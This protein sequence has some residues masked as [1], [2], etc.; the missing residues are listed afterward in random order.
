MLINL[1][2]KYLFYDSSEPSKI[3]DFHQP[4]LLCMGDRRMVRTGERI[5]KVSEE[6]QYKSWC[7]SGKKR[8]IFK[9]WLDHPASTPEV[10]Q[11]LF[12]EGLN[13]FEFDIKYVLRVLCDLAV[14]KDLWIYDTKGHTKTLK[15][16]VYDI[17]KFSEIISIIGY[18]QFEVKIKSHKN[19]KNEEFSFEIEEIPDANKLL[20]RYNK[21]L[22]RINQLVAKSKTEEVINLHKFIKLVMGSHIISGHNIYEYDNPEV[23]DR[24]KYYVEHK[25]L[26]PNG[27]IYDDFEEFL[28]KYTYDHRQFNQQFAKEERAVFFY[29]TCFDTYPASQKFLRYLDTPNFTLKKLAPVLGFKI[30]GRIYLRSNELRMDNKTLKY[31][32]DDVMEQICLSIIMLQQG[33]PMAFVSNY[34]F[35]YLT[36]SGNI[37]LWD[38]MTMIRAYQERVIFQPSV[39]PLHTAQELIRLFPDKVQLTKEE[40]EKVC[41][42]SEIKGDLKKVVRYGVEMPNWVT[43]PR[44]VVN[45]LT[46]GGLPIKPQELGSQFV[47]WYGVVEA[48]VA[49]MYP[50][51]LISSNACSDKVRFARVDEKPDDWIML[52]EMDKSSMEYVKVKKVKT[53]LGKEG[54]RV[55]IKID[56]ERGLIARP[57]GGLLRM[58]GEVRKRRKESEVMQHMYDSLKALRNAGTHGIVLANK[59]ACRQFNIA[60]G[61]LITTK[62]QDILSDIYKMYQKN[63]IRTIY[64]D[65]DGIYAACYKSAYKVKGLVESLS[66]GLDKL[67]DA[68]PKKGFVITPQKKVLKVIEEC[69]RRWRKKLNYKD[70]SFEVDIT[71]AMIIS[72]HKNYI[73]IK[74]DRKTG[75]AKVELKGANFT[76]KDKPNIAEDT[77]KKIILETVKENLQWEDEGTSAMKVTSAIHRLLSRAIPKVHSDEV[78]IKDLVLIQT[79]GSPESYKDTSGIYYKRAVALEELIGKIKGSVRLDFVVTKKPLPGMDISKKVYKPTVKPIAFM[80]PIDWIKDK[81]EIDYEWYSSMIMDY[82]SSCFKFDKKRIRTL[83]GDGKTA[84]MD[85]ASFL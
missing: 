81:S 71:P 28:E 54:F 85:L 43:L 60:S 76:A 82:V 83:I 72:M 12:E 15:V 48:D 50:N 7:D 24:V 19:L 36:T 20:S 66:D 70:F 75:K 52:W 9:V 49:G 39:S 14:D 34:P 17:E 77:L 80:T 62:G 79:V 45:H 30:K 55:G 2:N 16:L 31:N 37:Q 41:R 47:L 32:R 65:T 38:Y 33:L 21:G 63:R 84:Q 3:S 27:E 57:M 61:S 25:A 44:L 5:K 40:I 69:N 11:K 74:I 68:G 78:D 73:K 10:A 18:Y 56:K 59:W 1:S 26:V 22:L 51:L 64:G 53:A 58:I 6:M 4:Y 8:K 46:V 67:F 35:E 23:F 29:P 42:R 13:V